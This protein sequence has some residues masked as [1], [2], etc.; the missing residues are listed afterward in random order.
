M[1]EPPPDPMIGR[2]IENYRILDE[3]GRGHWGVVYRARDEDLRCDVAIKVLTAQAFADLVSRQGVQR[4]VV[5]LARINHHAVVVVHRLIQKTDH[6]FIVMEFVMGESLDERIKPGAL[7]E[8]EALRLGIH[9][10]Q[11]LT[12]VHAAGVIHRDLKP[13]NLRVRPDGQLKIVDF[14]LAKQ[15]HPSSTSLGESTSEPGGTAYYVAPELWSGDPASA[16][17]DLYAAGVVLY[18]MAT[19]VL[20]FHGFDLGAA[21]ATLHA[22]PVP[23]RK[24][25][26]AVSVE[27]EAVI[28]RCLEKDPRRRFASARDL[29]QALEAIVSRRRH[30]HPRVRRPWARWAIAAA[31]LVAVIAPAIV[32]V[33]PGIRDLPMAVLP[34]Q[35]RS[36]DPGHASLAGG[37]TEALISSFM[38]NSRLRVTPLPSVLLYDPP[39][40]PV[41]QIAQELGVDRIVE[42]SL[43]VLDDSVRI[44]LRVYSTGTRWGLL[45]EEVAIWNGTFDDDRRDLFDLQG[46]VADSIA[47]VIGRELDGPGPGVASADPLANEEYYQG[48]YQWNRRSDEG[49]RRA[50]DHFQRAIGRDR[51]FALAY[52]GLADAWATAGIGGMIRPTEAAS[53][54]RRAAR[55]ALDLNPELSEAY[56]SLANIQ[57]NFEWDWDTAALNYRRGIALRANNAHARHWYA[58]HLALRGKSRQ[59]IAEIKR[60]QR[61]DPQ[62]L[63]IHIGAGAFHY[64][65]RRYD[66]AL[67]EYEKGFELDSTSALLNRAMAASFIKLGR[68][69]DAA[70]AI[71]RWLD[72]SHPGDLATRAA[73][74]YRGHGLPGMLR[75]LV[76]AFEA[77]RAAGHY[78]PATRVAELYSLLS[79]RERAL[80]WLNVAYGEK[81]T[82][83][84]RLRVDPIFDPLRAD[85]RF[86]ALMH[87]V[88]L[89][90]PARCGGA[91]APRPGSG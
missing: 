10:A 15:T 24:R 20:P 75:V 64:Y 9:M 84:N 63:P 74:G 47:R 4:E 26:P 33:V 12:A 44:V 83:L 77:S 66:D 46:R 35:N 16:A 82:Q 81:D 89:T 90:D 5:A 6:Y 27:F 50:I 7:A 37:M 79:D 60:A 58:N 80:V 57:Q 23:P 91:P 48:R 14:G 36:G 69:A 68:D 86:T 73:E 51:N 42:G 70:H 62:S 40:K 21:H 88:G 18:Q 55:R 56:V 38:E 65:A 45:R 29:A 41:R 31:A 52:S 54:A 53:P 72:G 71:Q 28:L 76:G 34:L 43:W 1:A 13:S 22:P 87:K 17:S 32:L 78:V 49:V 39:R 61:L 11:G 8:D 2:R 59:A 30:P 85:P 25:N 19:G 67:E 3:I